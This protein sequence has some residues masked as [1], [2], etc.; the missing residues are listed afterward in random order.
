VVVRLGKIALNTQEALGLRGKV[1]QEAITLQVQITVAAAVVV[2]A[3]LVATELRRYLAQVV[4]VLPALF[5]V[6]P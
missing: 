6:Q 3:L 5:L 1:L 4:Q 2:Q